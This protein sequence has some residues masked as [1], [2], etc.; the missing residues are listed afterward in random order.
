[1]NNFRI[2][3]AC[4][5]SYNSGKLHG[6]WIDL[7]DCNDA[8]DIQSLIDEMLKSSPETGAEE[9]AIHDYELPDGICKSIAGHSYAD[10]DELI[11][12]NECD[13]PE[14]IAALINQGVCDSVT[15]AIRYHDQ[16]YQGQHNSLADYA[17]EYCESCGYTQALPDIFRHHIDYESMGRDFQLGGDI[18]TLQV[19]SDLHVYS[20]D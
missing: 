17:Q 18:F 12:I 5:A 20:N 6:K 7:N 2:Y 19:G 1:M 13:N 11:A 16:H 15:S 4:L 9:W 3:V 8:D 10:L 14:L